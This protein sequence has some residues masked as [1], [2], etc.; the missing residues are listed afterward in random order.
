MI[1]KN[2]VH[3]IQRCLDLVLPLID[4]WVIVDTGSTD[5]TQDLIRKALDGIPG[6]LH[7]RPWV[8][9]GY[10]RSEAITLAKDSGD[11]LLF[12]DADDKL[13]VPDGFVLPDLTADAYQI[14]FDQDG[15]TYR[16]T[17]VVRNALPWRYK[18]ALHEYPTTGTDI[19]LEHLA[20]LRVVFGGDG[21]RSRISTIEKYTEDASILECALA[22]DPADSRSAF[23]LAQSYRDAK[24]PEKA[25][26]AY[27]HRAT[28]LGFV[29]E[30]YVAM[31]SA[32]RLAAELGHAEVEVI[33]RYL[34]AHDARPSR[35]EALGEL[36]SYC[37]VTETRWGSARLF[38]SQ[39]LATPPSNDILFVERAWHAWRLLDEFA[40]ASYWLGD[41]RAALDANDKLLSHGRVPKDQRARIRENQK[42]AAD[43]L[44]V[45]IKH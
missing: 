38:A 15:V 13:V 43:K 3:V 18:G 14:D 33:D 37:R 29:E 30:R 10:N 6:E 11:Y 5:G 42:F 31:L 12:I 4:S 24:Q 2:E 17:C 41:Y 34:R 25:L 19:S 20:G 36:A 28:M 39:G 23:Y 40:I 45:K 22:R 1:V 8:D 7:E 44:G 9:F 16:R 21:S 35:V 27:D 32:A 26:A